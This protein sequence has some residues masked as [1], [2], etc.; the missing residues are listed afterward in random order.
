MVPTNR[1][2]G[3]FHSIALEGRCEVQVFGVSVES[4]VNEVRCESLAG[5]VPDK[6]MFE[7][8]K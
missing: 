7:R 5:T 4:F 3:I 1:G 6:K 2:S 8:R